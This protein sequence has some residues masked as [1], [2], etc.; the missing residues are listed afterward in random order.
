MDTIK[1]FLYFALCFFGVIW[2]FNF[3]KLNQLEDRYD[4]A[5]E[6]NTTNI[7]PFDVITA[8]ALAKT[9][10]I[11]SL[12]EHLLKQNGKF[13]L[14]KGTKEKVLNEVVQIDNKKYSYTIHNKNLKNLKRNILEISIFVIL[15]N[16]FTSL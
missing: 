9:Q 10:K 2:L 16:L 15:L 13:L 12:S 5:V 8:R 7:G 4:K 14:M 6:E 1:Y 3:S 11:I